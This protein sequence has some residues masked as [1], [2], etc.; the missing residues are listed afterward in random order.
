M[1]IFYLS[2]KPKKAAKLH[3]DKHVVKMCL[4]YTQILCTAHRVLDG[5]DG[6]FGDM[7]DTVLYKIS[8]PNH[9]SVIWAR[10]SKGN[11]KWLFK[12]WKA[13]MREYRYRYNKE[14]ACSSFYLLL[15]TPPENIPKGKFCSPPLVMTDDCKLDNPVYS[16]RLY[17]L[18]HK[19][20]LRSHDLIYYQRSKL[21][22]LANCQSNVAV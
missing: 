3:Y 8:H 6:K 7:R 14:H 1:N 22:R 2:K 15:K 12:L 17:Y 18:R 11:Y 4:E 13:L 19:D 9:P 16:Y 10:S 21:E 20:D 5:R